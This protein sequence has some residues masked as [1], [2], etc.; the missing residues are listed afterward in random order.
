ML[1]RI[2]QLACQLLDARYGSLDVI[3]NGKGLSHF[4]AE[5]ID[6]DIAKLC[7]LSKFYWTS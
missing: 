6:P 2:V 4:I 7:H 3:G 5:G 1:Q